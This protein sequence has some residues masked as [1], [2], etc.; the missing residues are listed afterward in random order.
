MEFILK[1]DCT[2]EAEDRYMEA[3]SYLKE[4]ERSHEWDVTCTA[5][6]I[7]SGNFKA[8]GG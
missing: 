8:V 1:A 6:R 4:H 5:L 7:A 3:H 2:F